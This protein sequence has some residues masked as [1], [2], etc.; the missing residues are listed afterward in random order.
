MGA[1]AGGRANIKATTL[2]LTNEEREVVEANYHTLCDALEAP[3]Q[4]A[5]RFSQ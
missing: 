4:K 5:P 1:D 3:Q 2:F